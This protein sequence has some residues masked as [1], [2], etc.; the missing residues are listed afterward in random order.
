MASMNESAALFGNLS[1]M[2]A[3]HNFVRTLQG[4]QQYNARQRQLQSMEDGIKDLNFRATKDPAL[5]KRINSAK[6]MFP[7]A[8]ASPEEFARFSSHIQEV[9]MVDGLLDEMENDASF[10]GDPM[11]E[12][13]RK[14][15]Q[16]NPSQVMGRLTSYL[17]GQHEFA[18]RQASMRKAQ[19]DERVRVAKLKT[20]AGSYINDLMEQFPD[21]TDPNVIREEINRALADGE[22]DHEIAAAADSMLATRLAQRTSAPMT[23]TEIA[24]GSESVAAKIEEV[25]A[26]IEGMSDEEKTV[27]LQTARNTLPPELQARFEKDITARLAMGERDEAK[28]ESIAASDIAA[29]LI[30]LPINE[31]NERL[32]KLGAEERSRVIK[33]MGE[34]FGLQTKQLPIIEKT[35][36]VTKAQTAQK[37][38]DAE[39]SEEEREETRRKES[40]VDLAQGLVDK[41]HITAD[42]LLAG[43]DIQS[44]RDQLMLSAEQG[45][46]GLSS[47]EVRE[48]AQDVRENASVYLARFAE[49]TAKKSKS[50]QMLSKHPEWKVTEETRRTKPMVGVAS[51][52][53]VPMGTDEVAGSE[54]ILF[55]SGRNENQAL[56][57]DSFEMNKLAKGSPSV[58]GLDKSSTHSVVEDE[59]GDPV[60][61]LS[62][63]LGDIGWKVSLGPNGNVSTESY[64][65]L[66]SKEGMYRNFT[67]IDD[68]GNLPSFEKNDPAIV[69]MIMTNHVNKGLDSRKELIKS[70]KDL[71]KLTSKDKNNPYMVG[72][73]NQL[74][75]EMIRLDDDGGRGANDPN[76]IVNNIAPS[77]YNFY[78]LQA[79]YK[80][81]ATNTFAKSEE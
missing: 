41:G 58:N 74:K 34:R 7:N 36:A 52:L 33:S 59:K 42:K 73:T 22:V 3:P 77:W 25:M 21:A 18:N 40:L 62:G 66:S 67:P 29:E 30:D 38:L 5:K 54:F 20:A 47:T 4:A 46:A 56:F 44:V 2:L 71:S 12:A 9:E 69:E 8:M 26:A 53:S 37:K 1:Q 55:P 43:A 60:Q 80:S 75:R 11:I 45:G 39:L 64:P 31:Q 35:I 57:T 81:A 63:G 76:M 51:G 72:L 27:A 15:A 13:Y 79:I 65:M 49:S 61:V 68:K 48:L 70:M 10:A 24:E 32:N 17:Q 14:A 23:D 19:G 28:E 78:R 16:S 6:T 50:L